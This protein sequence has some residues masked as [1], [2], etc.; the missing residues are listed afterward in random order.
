MLLVRPVMSGT[1]ILALMRSPIVILLPL[2]VS[3]CTLA[4]KRVWA[5]LLYYLRRRFEVAVVK[6]LLNL[7]DLAK[8]I[9]WGVTSVC[10]GWILYCSGCLTR[11]LRILI[12]RFRIRSNKRDACSFVWSVW[13]LKVV[14]FVGFIKP[15]GAIFILA[16]V[17]GAIVLISKSELVVAPG[18]KTL[19]LGTEIRER[20]L[21]LRRSKLFV[22]VL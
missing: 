15:W 8:D 10:E 21:N 7:S 16:F 1:C 9:L 14:I 2:L 5:L 6:V 3:S 11:V 20:T 12:C 18:C 22:L 19:G 17:L 13:V 4:L